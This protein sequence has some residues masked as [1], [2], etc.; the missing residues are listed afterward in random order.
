MRSRKLKRQARFVAVGGVAL[1]LLVTGCAENTGN[2]GDGA[3]QHEQRSMDIM[4]T[5]EDSVGPA[6]PV[7][8]AVEGG[9]ITFIQNADMAHLDPARSYTST[10]MMVGNGLIY[11]ALNGYREDGDG[12][13]KVVG[14][15]A[16]DPGTDVNGDCTVWEYTLKEGLKYEDGSEITADHVAYGVSRSMAKKDGNLMYPEG[17]QFLQQWLD[18][19]REYNGPYD[20]DP[21]APGIAVD[22]N[23]ITFSFDKPRCE[24]PFAVAMPT[25]APIPPDKDTK[26]DF[27]Q[28]PFSSGPYK[29]ESRIVSEKTVLVRNEH[30]D[31]NSDPIRHAYPD[32]F[33]FEYGTQP[34][35]ITT[36][37]VA[38]A[39]NDE[40]LASFS[41]V[42]P[43]QLSAVTGDKASYE[44]RYLEG[45]QK[46]TSYLS[47]NTNRV[48]DL[49]VR[50]ALNH[51][52]NR[53]RWI[54]V[55]GGEYAALPNTTLMGP[56]VPGYV[57]Y[58]VY[59]FDVEKAKELLGGETVK[60]RYAHQDTAKG[61]E[62]ATAM[63]DEF[64]KAGIEIEAVPVDPLDWYGQIAD[65]DNSF[66]IYWNGW[67]EDW[68]S[69]S[70]VFPPLYHSNSIAGETNYPFI[71]EPELDARMDEL[72]VSPE[73]FENIAEEW[74]KLGQ[75][76]MEKYAPSIPTD[77]SYGVW[78][79][80]SNIGG[81]YLQENISTI[82]ITKL[83]VRE[84]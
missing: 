63:A 49:K 27:D 56:T 74:G 48:T 46:Y 70:T 80:G 47:I 55:N 32:S 14:D 4:G 13:R 31:A 54:Q 60:I 16:T 11:R 41:L 40:N 5:A 35:D 24:T 67:G 65:P 30:W 19:E 62:I 45:P 34:E 29:I 28:A 69:G 77:L 17:A 68:P 8:G 12:S 22:G 83:F 25:T 26:N 3:Q 50:Q 72:M 18:P 75:E 64:A 79:T 39:S 71:T 59:P 20:D 78:L 73:G 6:T 81:Q 57:D 9:T 43:D 23:K 42:H 51:A 33:E 38:N 52:F 1:A 58:D 10:S 84:P 37:L 2:D 15:L 21:L 76:I 36:R 53:D 82:D 7:D 66:D 61:G 44:G